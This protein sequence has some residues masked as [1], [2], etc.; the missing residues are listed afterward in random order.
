M[1]R[2]GITFGAVS[3]SFAG[4]FQQ[5][6]PRRAEVLRRDRNLGGALGT[7]YGRGG[8]GG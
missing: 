6:H 2:V 3:P 5:N 7:G 8:N 1:W 4:Q